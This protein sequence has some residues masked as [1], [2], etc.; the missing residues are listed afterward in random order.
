MK[1]SKIIL[2]CRDFSNK[3]ILNKFNSLKN[4][5]KETNFEIISYQECNAYDNLI[6]VLPSWIIESNERQDIVSGDVLIT[7]LRKFI[8]DKIGR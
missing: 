6:N 1:Q 2:I 7:P 5:F 3:K 8:R 4:E